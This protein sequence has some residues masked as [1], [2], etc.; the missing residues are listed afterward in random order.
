[1]GNGE[2]ES[3]HDLMIMALT[4]VFVAEAVFWLTVFWLT[5]LEPATS[6]L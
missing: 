6:G 1:M 2:N 3:G 5:G 4:A